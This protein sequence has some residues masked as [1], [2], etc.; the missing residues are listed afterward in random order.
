[1][2]RMMIAGGYYELYGLKNYITLKQ[3]KTKKI[4]K[5][6]KTIKEK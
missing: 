3:I 1:M 2:I 5:A 4:F 6:T